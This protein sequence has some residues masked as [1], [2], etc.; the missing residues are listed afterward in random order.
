MKTAIK[1][2]VSRTYK[3]LL[4]KYLSKK[5]DYELDGIKLE[6]PPQVFHPG[7]FF[8]TRL[9]LNY[10]KQLQL[11]DKKFL[12]L[13]CGS[14][15]ISIYAAKKG[16]KVSSSD[17]NTVAIEFLK[18]NSRVNNVELDIVHSDLFKNI[19][20]QS[21]DIIAINPP[22]Y[23]KQPKTETEHAWYCGENGEYFSGLFENL[24]SYIHP[25]T[26]IYMVL[27]DGCDMKMINTIA[28][29]HN[30]QLT[31]VFVQK[32]LLEKNF[33]FKIDSKETA[34]NNLVKDFERIYFRLRQKEGRIYSDEEVES[35]PDI[36]NTHPY[37]NEWI[38]R[39]RSAD[40]LINYLFRKNKSL[41]ILEVGC[42]N[43]WL[44]AKMSAI[45]GSHVTGIDVNEYEIQQS[46]RVFG[47][48][49][50][51]D[52]YYCDLCDDKLH[53]RKFDTILFAAA[54][55][56]FPSLRKIINEALDHL[57]VEGEIHIIDSPFYKK[58]DLSTAK[59][60]SQKYFETAGFP[61]MKEHYFHNG[62]EDLESFN[63]RI[64]YNPLSISGYLRRS[65][66]PFYHI[67]IQHQ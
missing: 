29:K 48:K 56:Y 53:N 59:E 30:F 25:A 17:I 22:Y 40:S 58:N 14:G 34:Q 18:K 28:G 67:C 24:Y 15:L 10:L 12:E 5:R 23:K 46:K 63:C 66:N 13:G 9:L 33:I 39:K 62:I 50:N 43:G 49:E 26:E 37:F 7:F 52:F 27:F 19:P 31:C 8:S 61:G 32:N 21:F 55:Q 54:I 36:I 1:H 6:I 3:P 41:N 44:S 45:P 20:P 16:A 51:L 11:K 4:V 2:I 65:R 47:K 60:R 64:I 38:L 35:L 57:N 42:G